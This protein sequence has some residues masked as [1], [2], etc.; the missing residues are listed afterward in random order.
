MGLGLLQR[1]G[2]ALTGGYRQYT[3]ADAYTPFASS[4]ARDLGF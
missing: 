4:A 1:R 3:E 2:I